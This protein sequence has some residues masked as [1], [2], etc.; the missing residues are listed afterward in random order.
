MVD[1]LR[2]FAL[3]G[4]WLVHCVEGFEL[5]WLE[6]HPPS[7]WFD[8][9]FAVF[10]SKSFAIFALLFGFSF[11]TIMANGKSRGQDATGR[12]AWRLAVLLAI[13]TVHALL[14]RGDILQVLAV[15]GLLAIPL[16]WVRSRWTLALIAVI[17]F[18]QVPLWL[19]AYLALHDPAVAAVPPYFA[20]DTGQALLRDGTFWQVTASNAAEGMLSKWSFYGEVGRLTQIAGLVV[21]GMLLHRTRLFADA[22]ARLRTWAGIAAA[23]GLAWL[24]LHFFGAMLILPTAEQ[25]GVQMA[26]QNSDWALTQYRA[27]AATAFQVALFVLA[28]HSPLRQALAW[29]QAPGR[30]TLTLYVGQSV[31]GCLL[32]YGYAL[33]LWPALTQPM[34]VLGGI[35]LFAGQAALAHWWFARFA[36]G[37]LEW[38]WRAATLRRRDIPF[39]R[40]PA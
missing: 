2:G 27:L 34:L 39:R 38:L 33:A 20:T 15:L 29:L 8:A 7:A 21:T 25:G 23:G 37:P 17:L 6:A 12:F 30:M 35:A 32:L 24:A 28:W 13:G 11:A 1:A 14:Y 40:Q 19:R 5:Y 9:V 16:G 10:S 36:Y 26:W 31:I 22:A 18:L 3:L 4:L